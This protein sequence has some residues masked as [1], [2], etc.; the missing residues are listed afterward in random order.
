LRA[1][2]QRAVRLTAPRIA[3][4]TPEL[5]AEGYWIDNDR[6]F[7]LAEKL[8]A[9]LARVV[10]VPSIAHC[11]T[12]TASEIV[13]VPTLADLL[14]AH[15][16]GSVDLLALSTARFDMPDPNT[17]GVSAGGHDYRLDL[18]NKTVVEDK[19]SME[20][21]A[22]YSPDG[23]YTCF[24]RGYDLWLRDRHSGAERPITSDGAAQNSYGQQSETRLSAL[25]YRRAPTTIGLWSPDSQ[26]FLTHQIDERALPELPLIQNCPPEGIRPILHTYKFPFP[27]DPAP[28]A[29]YVAIHAATGRLVRLDAFP[30]DL[31]IFSPIVTR[32]VWFGGPGEIWFVRLDRYCKRAE[33]I[34]FDLLRETGRLAL[35]ETAESGYIDLHTIL[36]LTPNVRTL[37]ESNEIIW[38]SER[39]GWGHLYL[40]DAIT[41]ELK[42]RI[43]AGNWLVRDI[44]H[45][46]EQ[47]RRMLFLASG[48]DPQ[49]DPNRRSL[50]AVGLD[51]SGF[52]VLHTGDFDVYMPITEPAGLEQDAP[53]K[54]RHPAAAGL[55]PDGRH[56]V[57]RSTSVERGN[58]TEV[59][60]LTTRARFTIAAAIPKGTEATARR[61]TALA[62]DGKTPL[63]GVLFSPS[64]FNERHRYPL[65]DYIYPG[66][67]PAQQP[68]SYRSANSG[69][70]RALAE[71]GFVTLMLDTR[72]T[73][74]GSRERR[75]AGYGS[76][77][78]PQLA[79][80]AAV[81]RQLCE[82]FAFIDTERIGIFGE[83]AG[84]AATAR[85]LFDYGDVF[86]V[87]VAVCG[88]HDS[89]RYSS[90]WSDKYRGPGN[91]ARWAEQ[92][93]SAVA[94][95][96]RGKLLLM[97]ADTDENVH[98]SQTLSLVDALIRANRDFDL[99]IV[100]NEG[101]AVMTT[102]GYAQRRIWDYFVEHLLGLT[103]PEDFEI[104]F[105]PHQLAC[106]P[107]NYYREVR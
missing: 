44:V 86:K 63:H 3:S 60:N 16:G 69:Q 55:S 88:N 56:G 29:T 26:W 73:V 68:Q 15:C 58:L 75:Q 37:R 50:C 9:S 107:K 72:N 76:L 92:A 64:D 17:L 83:S 101:H 65:V 14:T 80:H 40:Y 53:H 59:V 31:M 33:L 93:N 106:F 10:P 103:P 100:P 70:A 66:P 84:G 96:L 49:A 52:E 78:E 12:Q 82:R 79:D 25:T 8:E 4:E 43:T 32:M 18:D 36:I 51:G 20:V 45:I 102:S 24:I 94:H 2:Y 1:R 27:G 38:F 13:S 85:A 61:F 39:D 87:G 54:P 104:R 74:I 62:A 47:S 46:D 35:S 22:I 81:V 48:I 77:L 99:L 23:R 98:L 21:P 71:I 5:A 19:P 34:Q 11:D 90:M 95:K 6:Y 89:S 30:I 105:E 7:F 97:C 91:G 28:R 57:I 67:V 41:G 42:N